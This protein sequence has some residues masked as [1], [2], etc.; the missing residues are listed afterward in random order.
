MGLTA[1]ASSLARWVAYA[2]LVASVVP[3]GIAVSQ[4]VKARRAPY[5]FQ[6]REAL[7][8]ATRW[9]LP[10]LA[11]LAIGAILLI[12]TSRLTAS[13]PAPTATLTSAPTVTPQSTH[14]L[15][16]SAMLGASVTPT[17]RP[18]ATPPAIP[19]PTLSVPLP[20]PA[21]SPLPSAV[22]AGEEAHITLVALALERDGSDQPVSPSTEFPPG[23]HRVYLFF[24]WE[25]MRNGNMTTFAWYKDGEFLDFCS[26]T[27]LWGMAEGRDWGE[28]GHISYYCKL[29]GGWE[30]GNY[31]IHVFIETL[32]QGVTQFAITE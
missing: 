30:P 12:V 32:L 4:F 26:D 6:R 29:P 28:R 13:A 9:M 7:R 21:L 11:A 16:P 17:R 2:L 19:T 27:W 3:I 5:Y 23:D 15:T 14:A 18:T 8:L 25:G 24:T 31:E 1:T 20:A 22:P 10:A